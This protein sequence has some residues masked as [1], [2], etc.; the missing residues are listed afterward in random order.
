[1]GV[2]YKCKED[3]LCYGWS[4]AQGNKR[5]LIEKSLEGILNEKRRIQMSLNFIFGKM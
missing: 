5:G 3:K 1:M 2:L 4:F